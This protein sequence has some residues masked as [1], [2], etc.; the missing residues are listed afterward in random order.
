MGTISKTVQYHMESFWQKQIRLEQL[1]QRECVNAE[2]YFPEL[3]IKYWT[4]ELNLPAVVK[5]QI[6]RT[7]AT[8]SLTTYREHRQ[9]LD[10]F[11]GQSQMPQV[12]P[13]P[14]ITQMMLG[15]ETPKRQIFIA[16]LSTFV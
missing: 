11:Q 5:P 14:G 9:N 1:T 7:A 10:I 6:D 8:P 12:T 15:S 16:V 3:D 13:Q 4:A 2:N